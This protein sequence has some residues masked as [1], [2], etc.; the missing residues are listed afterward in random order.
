METVTIR[1]A[2]K[3][4]Q[5]AYCSWH[6]RAGTK[7]TMVSRPAADGWSTTRYHGKCYSELDVYEPDYD[8][9]D[10][11]QSREDAWA[12]THDVATGIRKTGEI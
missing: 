10:V 12:L 4:Y 1:K 6:I 2:S 9:G 8:E 7:Y 11:I 5:C 3:S